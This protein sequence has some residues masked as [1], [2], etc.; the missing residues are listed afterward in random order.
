MK[1]IYHNNYIQK[2]TLLNFFSKSISEVTKSG[3]PKKK[4]TWHTDG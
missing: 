2:F 1:N 3:G 4:W